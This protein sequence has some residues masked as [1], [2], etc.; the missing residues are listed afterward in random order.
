[1]K[2]SP[3]SDLWCIGVLDIPMEAAAF[4]PPAQWPT[5]IAWIRPQKSFTFLADPFGIAHDDA[6]YLFA[7]NY[8]YRTKHGCIDLLKLSMTGEILEQKTILNEPW[9]LSY[10]FVFEHE[11]QMYMLPEAHRSGKLML[12]R[13]SHFPYTW[14]PVH[15]IS[16]H[17]LID[18]TLL[19][20]DGL[21]WLFYALPDAPLTELHLAYTDHLF[22]TWRQHPMNPIMR[23]LDCARPGGKPFVKD[24]SVYLPVQDNR[25]GYGTGLRLLC[26]ERLTTTDCIAGVAQSLQAGA[27]SYPFQD[28]LHTLSGFG[29]F[30]F[31]DVKQVHRS[32]VRHA[33]NWQRRLRRL[34]YRLLYRG[35]S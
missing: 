33:I 16:E 35:A 9:H 10:P 29:S 15:V 3:A 6:L 30:T 32:P 19:W 12:Y 26:I 24:G 17:P 7:E 31:F 11:G 34:L 21:W 27:W 18:P 4:L 14:E 1:M 23:G 13:A 2:L 22:G 25:H 5:P 20:H 8:D 28:G